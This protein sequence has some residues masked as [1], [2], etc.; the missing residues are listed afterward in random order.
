MSTAPQSQ[1][2]QYYNVLLMIT[3]G[4]INDMV[5]MTIL[6]GWYSGERAGV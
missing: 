1:A 3:D 5:N 2:Q 4:E 6:A